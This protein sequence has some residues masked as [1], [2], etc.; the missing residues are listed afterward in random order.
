M[1]AFLFFSFCFYQSTVM[2]PFYETATNHVFQ[3]Q[4]K[5]PTEINFHFI[6]QTVVTV[7]FMKLV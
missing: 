5:E 3:E 1:H 2:L 4:K 7:E 6:F